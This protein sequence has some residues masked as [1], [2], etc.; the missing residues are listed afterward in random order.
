[1]SISANLVVDP[2]RHLIFSPA[3]RDKRVV[4]DAR[5]GDFWIVNETVYNALRLS[6][7]EGAADAESLGEIDSETL[8]S[9][10]NHGIIRSPNPI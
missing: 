4:F 3:W 5:S 7:G 6:L 8:A 9:L 10:C 2:A 1:M